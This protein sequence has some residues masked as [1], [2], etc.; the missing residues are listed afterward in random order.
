M[1]RSDAWKKRKCVVKYFAYKDEL[2]REAKKYEFVPS[3]PIMITFHVPMPKSW[4]DKKKKKMMLKPHT[5][6]P[7]IDNFLKAYLD[8]LLDEDSHI[9]HLK[10][11]MKVWD[12]IGYLEITYEK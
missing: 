8:C 5:Q 3:N 2:R 9:Y 10:D 7:D 4:S 11:V 1:T 12:N 6:K